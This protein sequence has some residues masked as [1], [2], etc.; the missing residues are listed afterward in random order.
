[1]KNLFIKRLCC[2][3]FLFS[4]LTMLAQPGDETP[5]GTL[6]ETEA[7]A[8]PIDTHLLWLGAIGVLYVFFYFKSR[9]NNISLEE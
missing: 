2:L 4:N 7:P 3:F 1:M 5:D 6:E 9:K 8:A